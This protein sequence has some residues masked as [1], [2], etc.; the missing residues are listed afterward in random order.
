M[1]LPSALPGDW[2]TYGPGEKIDYFNTMGVTPEDLMSVGVGQGDIDWMRNNGY[3]VGLPQVNNELPIETEAY[4]GVKPGALASVAA[5]TYVEPTP[6]EPQPVYVEPQP[7]AQEPVYTRNEPIYTDPE[8]VD[9]EPEPVVD[10]FQA[11]YGE[12]EAILGA[13]PGTG[14][15]DYAWWAR[16]KTPEEARAFVASQNQPASPAP[17]A[18][19]WMSGVAFDQSKLPANFDWQNYLTRY[20]DLGAAGIDTPLEAQRHYALYGA[21]EGR[22]FAPEVANQDAVKNLYQSI[23][24]R[25]ADPGGL[26][27]WASQF[28]S[29]VSPEEEAAFRQAAQAEIEAKAP[30]GALSTLDKSAAIANLPEETEAVTGVKPR[31]TDDFRASTSFAE[32]YLMGVD[33]NIQQ[34][35]FKP[36]S[37]DRYTGTFVNTYKL[38]DGKMVPIEAGPEDIASG[39]VVFLVGGAPSGDYAGQDRVSQAYMMKDGQLTKVGSPQAYKAPEDTPFFREFL[40]EGVL[41]MALAAAGGLGLTEALG[42]AL[43]G[44]ALAGSSAAALGGGALNLGAQILAGKDP[45]DAL[46]G[47]VLSAGVGMV[48][49]QVGSMLPPEMATVGK[50][51]LTQLITTGKINPLALATSAGIAYASDTLAAETGLDKATAGKLVNAGYQLFQGNELGALSTLAQAA[52]S[53]GLGGSDSQVKPQDQATFLEANASPLGA[54]ALSPIPAEDEQIALNQLN[55]AATSLVSDYV[56]AKG[57]MEP[58]DLAE[59]LSQLTDPYG[60]PL[61]PSEVNRLVSAAQTQLDTQ[62]R[63]DKVQSDTL[64][65]LG[66]YTGLNSDLSRESTYERL[67]AAGNS[68]ERANEILNSVDTQVEANRAARATTAAQNQAAINAGAG[69]FAG[70]DQR[71]AVAAGAGE[72]AGADKSAAVNESIK[73]AASFNDAYAIARKEFGPNATFNYGGKLYSTATAEENPALSGKPILTTKAFDNTI[74]D[75]DIASRLNMGLDANDVRSMINQWNSSTDAQRIELLK[76]PAY[77]GIKAIYDEK[78]VTRPLTPQEIATVIRTG[79]FGSIS[80]TPE[81]N[82]VL[83]GR[84]LAG[85]IQDTVALVTGEPGNTAAILNRAGGEMLSFTGGALQYLGA[86]DLG[87]QLTLAGKTISDIGESTSNYAAAQQAIAQKLD[88]TPNWGDKAIELGKFALDNPGAVGDWI[89]TEG[90]QEGF[91][92]LAYGAARTG[93]LAAGLLAD[94]LEALGSAYNDARQSALDAGKS[95]TEADRLASKAASL[96]TAG[97]LATAGVLDAKSIRAM[98]DFK[99]GRITQEALKESFGGGVDEGLTAAIIQ[100]ITTGR[101]DPSKIG[102]AAALG[103]LIEGGTSGSLSTVGQGVYDNIASVSGDAQ[104]TKDVVNT[105]IAGSLALGQPADKTISTITGQALAAGGEVPTVVDAVFNTSIN[106]GADTKTVVNQVVSSLASNNVDLNANAGS[107]VSGALGGGASVNTAVKDTLTAIV[108]N[109][110]TAASAAPSII[111]AVSVKTGGDANSVTN[112]ASTII[113]N[114]GGD[115]NAAVAAIT[116]AANATNGNA[117]VAA[118]LVATVAKTG[119]ADATAAA[120]DAA[121]TATNGA[122]LGAT[123][124]SALNNNANANATITAA[125]NAAIDTKVQAGTSL[126]T[127][128]VGAVAASIGG[129]LNAGAS[130][131]DVI[132]AAVN[133]AIQAAKGDQEVVASV[134]QTSAAAGVG[135]GGDVSTVVAA[136]TKAAVDGGISAAT[137]AVSAVAGIAATGGDVIAAATAAS[138]ASGTQVTTSVEG[139][140]TVITATSGDTVTRSVVDAA[141]KT[142]LTSVTDLKTNQTSTTV[143]D[144]STQ[145]DIANLQESVGQIK[146]DLTA[147]IDA[148]IKAG[149]DADAAIQTAL[150][151]V[152]ASVGTTKTDLLAQLGTTEAALKQDFT[153]ALQTGLS[154]LESKLSTAIS[155][156]RSAGATGDAALQ[157]AIESLASDLGTTKEGLLSQLGTTEAALKTD[158]ASQLTDVSKT[159]NDAIAASIKAG[160]DADTAL[161]TS[162]SKVASDLGLTKEQLLNQIGK[163]ESA[164]KGDVKTL[165]DTVT[166]INTDLTTE[167]KNVLKTT[168]DADAVL[169]TSINKVASDLGLTKDQLLDQIGKTESQLK[170]E[171]QTTQD[172][173]TQVKTD[174]TTQINTLAKTTADADKIIASS[175]EKVAEDLG[176]TKKELLDTIGETEVSLKAELATELGKVAESL[177]KEIKGI[178]TGLASAAAIAAAQPIRGVS[179]D[180]GW[181]KGRMLQA[182]RAEGYRDPLAQFQ[183]LQEEAQRE[184][185]IKQLQPELAGVLMERGAMPYYAYGQEL[186]IDE[187]L[188]LPSEDSSGYNE[189]SEYEPVFRSGGKV[190]PLNLQMMY[191]KG[192]HTRE[193]FRHG[194]HV[195][196]PGDGQSDDIPAWLADGEF[197]FPADVVSALGNGSTKAGTEKLYEMMHSIRDR[198]RSK[199]PK[200][201]P[202]PAHKSPL[203]YL[204]SRK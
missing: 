152:A 198:A 187:A 197:V 87:K 37:T 160:Q 18:D 69:E 202:P 99:A 178:K 23:L 91:G 176:L 194:K 129:G 85:A 182:G 19:N 164:L 38:V 16:N 67:V 153:A 50:Q 14:P 171:I 40:I 139:G 96:S 115:K 195:A 36:G 46:K 73:N 62:L 189:E 172:T 119:N 90:L 3:I 41:P 136:T 48:A 142:T 150:D 192:G 124:T 180:D 53:S 27:Y 154:G 173:I 12:M 127:A 143:T 177:G 15:E 126:E 174:L 121:I 58:T 43:S 105:A 45:I 114:A 2:D 170:T 51:A 64:S 135:A 133:T 140:K 93:K 26:S 78:A 60:K 55:Q 33:P 112:A 146:T 134:L 108:G 75:G 123:V 130:A 156:A 110:G 80:E 101:L 70:A 193:D 107:V 117:T 94:G 97:T 98:Q 116:A 151:Q 163:T 155:D 138:N 71:T 31:T 28:G 157:K 24:G 184:E 149:Q 199:G 57:S 125:V 88:A 92:L 66:D 10:P 120:V 20:S 42:G 63:N 188:G 68:G 147:K 13:V 9:V 196:G 201:L 141:S 6:V 144:A 61:Q 179:L 168:Q 77:A 103:S 47:S 35:F 83:A 84:D 106:N 128:A 4:T 52:V 183:A 8:P 81:T 25:E 34:A 86:T 89:A 72:F 203:D 44:G 29:D 190:S 122:A 1:A 49:N 161:N 22:Q 186:S 82:W 59:A 11:K 56:A 79:S 118:D 113:A 145:Q 167:I 175:I 185:M 7:V 74:Q 54:G 17:S 165:S 204:K 5:P 104:V 132:N 200:D 102:T 181:L 162:I 191:A 109:G 100:Q 166:K 131:N 169:N 65:I 39:N 30:A 32:N 95:I 21:T 148:S 137:A 159:L 76:T 158:F 111:D